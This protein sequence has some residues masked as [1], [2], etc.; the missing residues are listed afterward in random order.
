MPFLD[1]R[2]LTR[3]RDAGGEAEIVVPESGGRRG[4]EPLCAY[5][6]VD[7]IPAIE[8]AIARGDH[9]VVGFYDELRVRRIPLEEVRAIGEPE[10][11]FLNVNTPEE[12]ARAE[13]IARGE[14][15]AHGGRAGEPV[16]VLATRRGPG[17]AGLNG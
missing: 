1:P 17:E 14:G 12:R 11:L 4:V 8:A 15:Q 3:L 6:S 9:R 13:E 5:Y 16:G 2:L 7:C 10:L